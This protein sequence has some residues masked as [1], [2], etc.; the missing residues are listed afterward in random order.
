M[1]ALDRSADSIPGPSGPLRVAIPTALLRFTTKWVANE[2][3]S[4]G[5]GNIRNVESRRHA[6][7]V[8]SK[9]VRHFLSSRINVEYTPWWRESPDKNSLVAVAIHSLQYDDIRTAVIALHC[10]GVVCHC[11]VSPKLSR[12]PNNSSQRLSHRWQY[13]HRIKS[14]K[15]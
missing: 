9:Y 3:E 4:G 10:A 14:D 13:T 15:R 7:R 8:V 12:T 11:A 1:L 2:R 5:M 6:W